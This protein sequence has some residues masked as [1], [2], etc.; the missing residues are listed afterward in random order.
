M[1]E[2]KE[3]NKGEWRESKGDKQREVY[4]C[5]ADMILLTSTIEIHS[6]TKEKDDEEEV[7]ARNV[8]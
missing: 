4:V 6:D 5:V 7:F 3:K 1:G 8:R 2:R